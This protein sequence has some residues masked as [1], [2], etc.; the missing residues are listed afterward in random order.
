MQQHCTG[1]EITLL[2][3]FSKGKGR[4]PAEAGKAASKEHW[5]QVIGDLEYLQ[6][7]HARSHP[8][9]S[10]MEPGA[11]DAD[12]TE[13]FLVHFHEVMRA[14]GMTD[15]P[16]DA[17]RREMEP[18]F[19]SRPFSRYED[20]LTH[21]WL[22]Q[23]QAEVE[24]SCQRLQIGLPKQPVF[25]TL[26][27]GRVNGVA[28]DVDNPSYYLI[29]IDDGIMGFANLLSKV[30]AVSFPVVE[31]EDGNLSFSTDRDSVVRQRL[32]SPETGLRFFDLLTAYGIH[33]APHA[34][35]SYLMTS[36]HTHLVSVF[37]DAME[38]FIFG[39]EY[40]HCAAGH[41]QGAPRM[42]LSMA[43]EGEGEAEEIG[44][45]M[46]ESWEKELEAD[47]IGL[48]L[49][50]DV[51]RARG[52]SPNLSYTGIELVFTGVD[53]MQRTLSILEHGVEQ[54]RLLDTHPPALVRREAMRQNA[55]ALLGP[56][57]GAAAG[58]LA[59][60]VNDTL[61]YHWRAAAPALARMHADGYRPHAR[62]L[63]K[64]Q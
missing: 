8:W 51:M 34:A 29:L 13:Q 38:Y 49:A 14:S 10:G 62:W 6:K 35:Q 28:A 3:W 39:H 64:A 18:G 55:L 36:Q 50:M 25:G 33:G 48:A 60:I 19:R 58:D 46:P 53:Y 26:Q 11:T 56:E 54:E 27:T 9:L 41:L 57:V 22:Q 5:R 7:V 52:Y 32:Q 40:G 12:F 45:R 1:D 21:F 16:L 31:T 15:L 17:W 23:M 59:D 20:P 24:Q 63:Q 37:R 30:A 61:E 47:Y 2:N 42:S 44:L 43:A 4:Q